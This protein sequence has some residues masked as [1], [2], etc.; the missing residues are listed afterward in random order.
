MYDYFDIRK[1]GIIDMNKGSRS[2]GIFSRKLD[3]NEGEK[4]NNSNLRSW[5]ITNNILDVYKINCEKDKI[6]KEK[7][8]LNCVSGDCSIIQ[9]DNLIQILMVFYL[10]LSMAF[11]TS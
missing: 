11:L 9:F 7:V 8:K 5:E 10:F 2:F 3:L 4:S 6:I 1:G